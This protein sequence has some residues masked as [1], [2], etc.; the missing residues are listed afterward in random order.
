MAKAIFIDRDG[1]L[2]KEP[3]FDAAIG[4]VSEVINDWDKFEILSGVD[5]A[6]IKLKDKG[7][8]LL[9]ITNQD[10]IDDGSLS[11]D[12]YAAMNDKLIQLTEEQNGAQI[13]KIYT[14][15]HSV[16]GVCECRKP[17]RGLVDQALKDY[18]DVKLSESW[19][20]GD[21]ATDMELGK[22]IGVKTIFLNSNHS[23]HNDII[24][25]AT[26]ANIE[27]AIDYILKN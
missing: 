25:N 12:L 26:V 7:F 24:P 1:V 9:V 27:S 5:K 22:L 10:G 20:I 17:K 21:R 14:C 15:P 4:P 11:P 19:L 3:V 23:L 13:D 2:L 6:F 8:R 18:P 16:A